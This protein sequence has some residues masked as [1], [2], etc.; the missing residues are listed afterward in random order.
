MWETFIRISPADFC[1][2]LR[3]KAK[4]MIFQLRDKG[5]IEWFCFL[6]HDKKSGVPTSPDD[7]N[8]YVHI[9]VALRENAEPNDF[10][11]SLPDYCVLTR[12]I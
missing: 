10:L 1:D 12:K 8:A 9:R 5:T 3:F 6:I 11:K 7:N 4:P 2:V